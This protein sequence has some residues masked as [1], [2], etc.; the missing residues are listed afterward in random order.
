MTKVLKEKIVARPRLRTM[1][2]STYCPGCHYGIIT[3][4]ICEVIEELGIEGQAIGLAGVGCSFGSK[5]MHIDI[6]FCACPH[7]RAPAMATAIKRVHPEAIV[8]TCQGDGDLGAIGLGCFMNALLRGEKLTTFF[9]NNAGY[10]QTGGQMA[11]TTLLGMPTTTTTEGRDP[12]LSGYP[13]HGAELAAF[14]KGVAYSA[15]VSVHTP[16]NF[17]RA[18]RAVRTALQKQ[19]HGIGYGFVEFLSAC[20]A[21]WRLTPLECLTFIEDRMIAEYP[22]GEFKNMDKIE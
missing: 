10:G 13:F 16:A 17:R 4:I 20:P 6:D 9:L 7:G 11:P 5:P 3:R 2:P 15:R 1:S 19:I 21:S 18:K 14:V 12:V 8:F 22:L